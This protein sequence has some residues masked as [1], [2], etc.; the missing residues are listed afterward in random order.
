MFDRVLIISVSAGAGHL[1]AA[2]AVEKA[3]SLLHAAKEVRNIDALPVAIKCNN[4][5]VLAYKI[6]KLL[7][8]PK[9]LARM[10]FKALGLARP[11]AVHDIVEKLICL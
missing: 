11:S 3:F 6:D 2:Q 9:H 8:N 1:R 10:Q 7:D 4:W 5:P